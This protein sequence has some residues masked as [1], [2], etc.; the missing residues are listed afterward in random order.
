MSIYLW[1]L[2]LFKSIQAFG[3]HILCWNY[4]IHYPSFSEP[5]SIEVLKDRALLARRLNLKIRFSD[6]WV[7]CMC[8]LHF[9]WNLPYIWSFPFRLR[10]WNLYIEHPQLSHQRFMVQGY[11]CPL[12]SLILLSAGRPAFS[13]SIIDY[14]QICRK[15]LHTLV[16][17]VIKGI[18]SHMN[19][20][21]LV[22]SF[23][24][25]YGDRF[26][27]S[28]QTIST[29]DHNIFN[30]TVFAFVKNSEPILGVFIFSYA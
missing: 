3:S 13:D 9:Q 21:S 15:R 27:Y 14:L 11:F 5:V 10:I 8:C 24:K 7:S 20:A 23:R 4:C 12:F 19:Y 22:F 28:S 18:S 17:D 29:E 6:D 16:I 2:I 1:S 25:G 26:F 30:T